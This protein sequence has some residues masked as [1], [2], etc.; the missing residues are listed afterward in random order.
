MADA[1][2]DQTWAE[3]CKAAGR[4]PDAEARA[5]LSAV[6]FEEYP[7]FAY[8][9]E[10]V[11]RA[12]K[13]SERMLKH[14]DAFAELYR[15]AWLPHLPVDEFQAIL[16]GRASPFVD[17]VK[18]ARDLWYIAGLRRRPLSMW[19]AA[20]AIQRAN[21]GKRNT[22]HEWLCHRLCTIWLDYFHANGL[23]ITRGG[24][25]IRFML[26]AM[27]QIMPQEMPSPETVRDGIKRERVERDNAAQLSFE[28]KLREND[29]G[30]LTLGKK[31]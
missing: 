31:F 13:R 26:A 22:Q 10:R 29:R 4:T 3:F 21:Q 30:G 12:R 2:S 14:L 17:D 20:R 8:H 16:N 19:L 1:L 25:L 27:R 9:R 11:A 6:L 23:S 5:M 24:P 18:T 28:F 7:A 15:Q